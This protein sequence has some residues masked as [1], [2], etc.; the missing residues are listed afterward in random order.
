[1]NN[2][3]RDLKKTITWSMPVIAAVIMVL[4]ISLPIAAQVTRG[5][6]SGMVTDSTGAVVSGATITI[7]ETDTGVSTTATSGSGGL[8]LFL[9]VLPGPYTLTAEARG[10]K[11]LEKTNLNVITGERFGVGTLQLEV[12]AS[13]QIVMVSSQ[14]SHVELES[15]QRDVMLTP[16]DL[17]SLPVVNRSYVGLLDILPGAAGDNRFVSTDKGTSIV[18]NFNGI[19]NASSGLFMDGMQNKAQENPEYIQTGENLDAISEIKVATSNYEAQYGGAGGANI[20]VITKSGTSEFHGSLYDYEGNEVFDANDFFSNRN[21]VAR[22]RDRY[23]DAG[24]S[25]GGPIYWPDRFNGSKN[26]LFFFVAE[27]Y[28]PSSGPV[29]ALSTFTMPTA[30]QRVGDFSQTTTTAGVLVPILNPFDNRQPFPGNIVPQGLINPSGQALLN[31]FPLP[32]F[33]NPAVSKNNYNYVYQDT[34]VGSSLSTFARVDYDPTD[35]LRMFF[36]IDV[37]PSNSEAV[38]TGGVNWPMLLV[39]HTSNNIAPSID[40][41][42]VISPKLVNEFT[43]G[44]N[45]FFENFTPGS[46]LAGLDRTAAG[47]DIGRI[48]PNSSPYNIVPQLVFGGGGLT[49]APSIAFGRVFGARTFAPVVTGSDSLTASLGPHTVKGGIYLAWMRNIKSGDTTPFMGQ[50]NFNTSTT[51]PYDAN[52]PYANALLGTFNTYNESNG[53][54]TY[55]FR[56]TDLEWYLQDTWK[57]TRRLTLTYGIRFFYFTP[58]NQANGVGLNFVPSQYDPA[59]A[60]RLY[61]PVINS[62]NQRVAEDPLTGQ[63]LPAGFIGAIVPGSGDPNNGLVSANSPDVPTGFMYNRGVQFGPRFGFAYALTSDN[64]TVLRGGFGVSYD[65]HDNQVMARATTGNATQTLSTYNGTFESIST[66]STARFP[67]SITAV[68][69]H[70]KDPAVYSESLGI[71]R[72]IGAGTL[73]DIAYVGT[74]GQQLYEPQTAFNNV[75]PGTQFLPEN[76]DPT[77]PGKPLPDNFFRPYMGYANIS[78]SRSVNSNYNA[79]QVQATRHFTRNLQLNIGYTWSKAMGYTKPVATYYDNHLNYGRLS[80][81]HAHSVSVNY[82]YALPDASR[83]LNFRPLRSIVD[84]WQ[85]S[86]ILRFQSGYPQSVSCGRTYSVNL[87]GGGDAGRCIV[88]GIAQLPR[89]D[90]TF[91]RYFNTSVFQPPTAENSG[92]A[93]PDIFTGPGIN[94]WDTS[95][96][97]DIPLGEKRILQ[98]RLATFNTWNHPQFNTVN[99][100]AQF[101]QAGEQVNAGFGQI[102]GGY[103]NPRK[104]QLALKFTF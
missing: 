84:N 13:T 15:G 54:V 16:K 63:L 57:T 73:L 11:K 50:L 94:N 85:L 70:T 5:S 25:F 44:T 37:Q 34:A 30:A 58:W 62:Q 102:N 33:I 61:M 24:G 46:G 20:Q 26:K 91:D 59:Q 97:K 53:S 38:N 31:L 77:S 9:E 29:G 96:F 17:S 71:Q 43:L 79:L 90:R 83:V 40:V 93:R 22:P 98:F 65:G 95:V 75:A 78:V 19:S 101:N 23:R 18:P 49:D 35:K 60:V 81:D 68:N 55:D 7:T 45:D 41:S 4:G 100:T 39:K 8:F 52:H 74:F 51:N 92:N 72:E 67:V 86:G 56:G 2:R 80:I 48:R 3:I 27:D 64:K 14:G 12:G 42:Y 87:Y 1:M 32:N 99:T 47:V 28:V 21:G 36:R 88:T 104:I 69:P 82:I 89:S 76:Q 10:F 6:V 103:K 66:A